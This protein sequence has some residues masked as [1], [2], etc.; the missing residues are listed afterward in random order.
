[1]RRL[2][3]GGLR[4]ERHRRAVFFEVSVANRGSVDEWLARR[5]VEV[6]LVRRGRVLARLHAEP[7]RVLAR[8]RGL[9]EARYAGRLRGRLNAVVELARPRLGVTVLRRTF[10]VR[11]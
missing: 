9:V 10:R 4:F 7:R 11:L 3:V 8:T 6:R 1:M 2:T 5:R